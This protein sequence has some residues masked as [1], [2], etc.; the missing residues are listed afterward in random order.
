MPEGD[1]VSW[2]PGEV[3][4]GSSSTKPNMTISLASM[5]EKSRLHMASPELDGGSWLPPGSRWKEPPQEP[6]LARHTLGRAKEAPG[7]GMGHLP[8][9]KKKKINGKKKNKTRKEE[10]G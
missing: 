6:H 8:G 9:L 3:G 4:V 1:P 10:K 2:D 7:E 5:L